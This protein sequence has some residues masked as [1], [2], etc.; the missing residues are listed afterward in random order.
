[1]I[2]QKEDKLMNIKKKIEKG[3][4][5]VLNVFA[6]FLV[7]QTANSACIWV[8]YQPEFPKAASKFKK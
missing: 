8:A 5:M 7:T 1:M 4:I 3:A 2:Q 6:L